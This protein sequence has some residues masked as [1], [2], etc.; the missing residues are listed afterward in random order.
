M[1]L[2][3]INWGAIGTFLFVLFVLGVL[4]MEHMD[5]D[6][7]TVDKNPTQQH[8][9]QLDPIDVATAGNIASRPN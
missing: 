8:T 1:S 2:R 5:Q 9:E 4:A 3:R 6:S 7:I